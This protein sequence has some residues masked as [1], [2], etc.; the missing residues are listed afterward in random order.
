MGT[1]FF[2]SEKEGLKIQ[3]MSWSLNETR[4]ALRKSSFNNIPNE[5]ILHIFRFL[6]VPDLCNI[7]LVCRFFK[8][9]AD[10]DEIWKS[11]CN[12]K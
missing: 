11:K 2:K 5:V 4:D 9:I 12:S 10:Q 3:N 6:S 8:M 1:R 7:S